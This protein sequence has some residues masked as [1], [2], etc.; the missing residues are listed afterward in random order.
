[1]QESGE[2][3]PDLAGARHSH[4]VRSA[5]S[6]VGHRV[7][8]QRGGAV[9]RCPAGSGAGARGTDGARGEQKAEHAPRALAWS[10]SGEV[11][12]PP[13]CVGRG[14]EGQQK[15]LWLSLQF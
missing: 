13:L 10:L 9:P 15:V 6:G 12:V 5:D 7:G 2:S 1:M 11:M 14:G 4:C 3:H 8:A